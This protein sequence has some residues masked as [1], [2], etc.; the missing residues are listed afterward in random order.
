MQ[1]INEN[2]IQK[3]PKNKRNAPCCGV[4]NGMCEVNYDKYCIFYLKLV[5]EHEIKST[6]KTF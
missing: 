6:K 5:R 3:C 4:V 2:L 1:K